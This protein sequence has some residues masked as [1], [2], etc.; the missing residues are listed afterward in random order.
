ML[1][2]ILH[3]NC[4]ILNTLKII[5]DIVLLKYLPILNPMFLPFTFVNRKGK[6]KESTLTSKSN[7]RF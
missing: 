4:I 6:E 5:L 1:I 2:T 7:S 3:E